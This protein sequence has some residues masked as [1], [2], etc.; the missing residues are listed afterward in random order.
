M[1]RLRR[2]TIAALGATLALGAAPAAAAPVLDLDIHHDPSHFAPGGFPG[3]LE[4]S[5]ASRGS[6][7]TDEVQ[8]IRLAADSGSFKLTFEGETTAEIPFNASGV[9]V[10]KA[11]EALEAIG[12]GNVK[13]K[14]TSLGLVRTYAIEFVGALAKQDVPQIGAAEG[15][16]PLRLH[17]E[18]YSFDVWN[19]GDEPTGGE[20]TLTLQLQGGLSRGAFA[21]GG[22]QLSDGWKAKNGG[23]SSVSWDCSG[24]KA[25]DTTIECT[26]P[27]PIPPHTVNDALRIDV[28]V[29]PGA[30]EGE[31]L[32]TAQVS[33][34]G[35][36]NA[37]E[38]A[39]PTEIGTE[40]DGF[41]LLGPSFRPEFFS[42]EAAAGGGF[43]VERRSGA[44]PALLVFPFDFASIADPRSGDLIPAENVRDFT[45]DLPPG[46]LG[47][48]TAVGECSQA[49]FTLGAC[50]GAA[51]V[52]RIDAKVIGSLA[53]R[54]HIGIFNL[55]HPRGAITDIALAVAGNPVHV[56]AH[57]DPANGY[58][59]TTTTAAINETFPVLRQRASFWGVPAAHSHDSE[60][61]NLFKVN[62]TNTDYNN[63][64]TSKECSTDHGEEPFLTAPFECGAEQ[65][66][67]LHDYDS[68]QHPGL[69]NSLPPHTYTQPGP[70]RGCAA[71]QAGFK[72]EVSLTPTGREANIPTGLDVGIHIPQSEN[73]NAPA[74]PPVASTT[75]TLPAGM[76]L[77]PAFADGLQGCSEAE[78]GISDA[79]VPNG[80]PIRCPDAS[81]IGE[82]EISSPLLPNP[83]EGSM[84]L[85]KQQANPFGSLL[86]LYMAVHDNEERGILVKLAGRIDLDPRSGQITQ[87]FTE[88][89]QFPFE[90]LTLRFRS[91]ERAPLVNPPTCG[92]HT[93][94]VK[95]AS[96]AQ[97]NEPIDA[98]GSY[99]VEE[100]SGGAPCAASEASRPFEPT[101]TAGTLNPLAGAFSPL[102]LRVTRSDADQEI[103]T[104]QGTA[105]EG[106]TASLRGLGRCS[107]AQIA[108]AA[109]RSAPG[110]GE[111]ER[112]RPSC[113]ASSLIGTVQA[114]A[115]AG[116]SP[117]YVPGRVYLAGPYRGAPLSGVAIVPAIAGP[118]DLGT[119]VVRAPAYVD[120]R[121]AQVRIASDPLPQI[122]HGVLVRVREIDLDLD[123]PGFTL[124]PTS[125]E[126]K[127]FEATLRS[128]AGTLKAL[129]ERFQ[130]FDC[131]HLGFR[132][133]L[134]LKL[135]GGSRRG[136]HPALRSVYRPRA[137]DANLA[138]LSVRLPHSAFL[139]QAHI[140]TICTRVQFAAERCPTAAIYGHVRAF[141]PLL[142]EPLEGPVY[143]RSSSHNLPD[144]VFDL[145]GTIDLE[146][147][148]RIDS[149]RGGIRATFSGV[150][151]APISK[152]VLRMQGAQK[153]L[154]VN[155]TDLCAGKHR[156]NVRL[157]GHNG[158]QATLKPLMRAQCGKS[159]SKRGK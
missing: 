118:V 141:T 62:E 34:G 139:E 22:L 122:V 59:I 127:S 64:D 55:R 69:P 48:P 15:A 109:A 135:I 94:A 95:I 158:K 65:R 52:G 50:S 54:V 89:P 36:A 110:E 49:V 145:H 107:E 81:R 88:L 57:L 120:P 137:G 129:A 76:A 131:G 105:P 123:R 87:T 133:R 125:C 60:R 106:L 144:L 38:A 66:V 4:A 157:D 93:I 124:N 147:V 75:V 140:R 74:T 42:E 96:Y 82:V 1:R 37:A 7:A 159:K 92:T 78:F 8:E 116:P 67:T 99:R 90:D 142:D 20:V 3:S 114:G 23:V 26:T 102:A 77:N 68:W 12:A 30:A 14:V 40:P 103:A 138:R 130:V 156:A 61:C 119:I 27:G 143:L 21:G 44:H 112:E 149:R 104:V 51:Q 10:R 28:A 113:P 97:P 25:G 136:A 16:D 47:D 19:L 108:A 11:L 152:V 153:G 86:A 121:S 35:A 2:A 146:A 63:G 71:A 73:P 134:W 18:R 154:I 84:Y 41:G 132:P 53:P 29:D 72:P 6:A 39:E 80:E 32:A 101:L 148:A 128:T 13:G 98:S 100:G 70:T 85:A 24:S 9:D 155:S 43:E 33:G 150:P 91:G 31:V 58:A 45:V 17:R 151:D 56:K 117:I 46:F 115:G 126:Q 111:I 79:G 5:T 83:I